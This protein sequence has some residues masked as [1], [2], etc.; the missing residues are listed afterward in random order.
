M[1]TLWPPRLGGRH[2]TD[3]H[4]PEG[5]AHPEAEQLEPGSDGRTSAAAPGTSPSWQA[6]TRRFGLYREGR[7][8]ARHRLSAPEAGRAAADG[9]GSTPGPHPTAAPVAVPACDDCSFP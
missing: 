7:Q 3:Q 5:Q 8:R 6:H 9:D 2:I 1:D 4:G